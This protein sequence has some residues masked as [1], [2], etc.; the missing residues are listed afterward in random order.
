MSLKVVL[1]GVAGVFV[2]G[3]FAL[4]WFG[5]GPVEVPA[6]TRMRH[7]DFAFTVESAGR[8]R[9][10]A[11]VSPTVVVT[12]QIE[13]D[14]KRVGY[15]WQPSTAYV[16]DSAGR[17]YAAGAFA[18]SRPR[19]IAAGDRATVRLAYRVPSDARDLHLAF[20]DGVMMGDVFD[21]GRYARLR[22][23]LEALQ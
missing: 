23:R 2:L 16:V 10:K 15:D 9:S 19:T 8:G 12:L 21:G 4:L 17:R 6:S 22:V 13:N 20:W 5:G 3:G 7:D 1:V 14:T 18:S 11:E